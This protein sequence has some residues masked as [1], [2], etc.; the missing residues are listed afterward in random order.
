MVVV[1]SSFNETLSGLYG[2]PSTIFTELTLRSTSRTLGVALKLFNKTTTRLPESM[3]VHFSSESVATTAD[4]GYGWAMDVLGSA[5][6]PYDVDPKGTNWGHAIWHGVQLTANNGDS[7]RGLHVQSL[8]AAMACPLIYQRDMQ[9]KPTAA[10]G[11]GLN[12]SNRACDGWQGS[13]NRSAAPHTPGV[14]GMGL[15]LH[16][17][18]MGISGFAQWYPFGIKSPYPRLHPHLAPYQEADENLLYRFE[19]HEQQ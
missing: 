12:G 5:V 16:S 7:S 19:L 18:R 2:A 11:G 3:V 14:G 10:A 9:G 15:Q 6:D 8:D 13:L 1:E 17:N 4:S